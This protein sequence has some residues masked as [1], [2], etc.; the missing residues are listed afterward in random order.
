MWLNGTASTHFQLGVCV[1][2]SRGLFINYESCSSCRYLLFSVDDGY[3]FEDYD[4]CD[5]IMGANV[6]GLELKPKVFIIL[7]LI[8]MNCAK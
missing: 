2:L 8:G 3:Q 4:E 5:F 1:F 7:M 6:Q